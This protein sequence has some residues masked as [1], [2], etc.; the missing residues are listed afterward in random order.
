MRLVLL[1]E[2]APERFE[3]K[4]L[5]GFVLALI[6]QCIENEHVFAVTAEETDALARLT[7]DTAALRAGAPDEARRL[8]MLLLY[9][10]HNALGVQLAP[11]LCR[12]IRPR[13]LGELLAAHMAQDADE[14]RFAPSIPALGTIADDTSRK[15]ADQYEAHP[16]P[17]WTSL[18][19]PREASARAALG[20]YVAPEALGFLDRPFRVL[21]AG[22][23]T[24]RHAIAASVRYGQ[25]ARVL[26]VDLSRRSLA[27]AK[28]KAARFGVANLEFAQA[29]L[30]C[31]PE[32]A[33]PFDVIEAVGVLHHMAEPFKGWQALIRLLRPGGLML[34]GLYSA[35]SRQNIAQLRREVS[36][37]GPGCDDDAARAHR[38]V[39][40]E[41]GGEITSSLDFY[42][43]SNFR[44]LVLHEHERP[45]FLSEIEAFLE[46]NG[47]IF[48]GFSLPALMTAA[49]RTAFPEERPGSLASWAKFEEQYP[50]TFDAMYQIWCEK[51]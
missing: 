44:D 9:R 3:D 38:A 24:G 5:S 23:G 6:R 4:A 19:M 28:A 40:L 2:V 41:R 48:R 35:V 37:P 33:G 21:I 11:E 26:A 18:Q 22:A 13:A 16:Y 27:Y 8:M 43:L 30:L 12:A 14:A 15:V 46:Q 45:I 32:D 25:N 39:L 31:I 49:F 1:L 29:D 42:A 17:R 51:A 10:S 7:V 50:H 20:A 47:L 36:Y 34:A